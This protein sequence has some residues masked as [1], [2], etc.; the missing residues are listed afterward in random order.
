MTSKQFRLRPKVNQGG[1]VEI[2]S[3]RQAS[4]AMSVAFKITT[5]MIGKSENRR[6]EIRATE[7]RLIRSAE[8]YMILEKAAQDTEDK[9][10]AT[11]KK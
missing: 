5:K 6:A 2:K 3:T 4:R 10:T 7:K 1:Q 9:Q 8:D 11:Q